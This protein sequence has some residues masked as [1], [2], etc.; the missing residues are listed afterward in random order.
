MEYLIARATAEP[1]LKGQWLGPAWR[2]VPTA[3]LSHFH[4]RSSKHR[5]LVETKIIYNVDSLFVFFKV[6]DR[7]I[8]C[9]RTEFQASVCRDSCVEIFIQPKPGQG[10]M[11]YEFN[12][13]GTLQLSYIEDPTRVASGFRKFVLV[14]WKLASQIQVFHSMPSVVDPEISEPREWLLEC[15]IPFSLFEVYLGPLGQLSGQCWHGNI[16]KC[17]DETSHP[18]WAAWAPIGERL[19]FHAPEF[20]GSFRFQ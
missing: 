18:H 11:N 19:D 4:A 12:C 10:Y 20:F 9:L 14:P 7:Y 13:G 5:P 1:A 3:A 2:N 16:Y 15:R 8:R 17:A 6:Q